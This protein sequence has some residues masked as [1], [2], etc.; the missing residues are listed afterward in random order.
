MPQT[1]SGRGG[2]SEEWTYWVAS[3]GCSP[4]CR[5]GSRSARAHG[6]RGGGGGLRRLRRRWPSASGDPASARRRCSPPQH[7]HPSPPSYGAAATSASH[8]QTPPRR[9]D[10]RRTKGNESAY[11]GGV[12]FLA[13]ARL[14][15]GVF[16]RRPRPN[17]PRRPHHRRRGSLAGCRGQRGVCGC[18]KWGSGRVVGPTGDGEEMRKRKERLWLKRG[19]QMHP[20][21]RSGG[22]PLLPHGSYVRSRAL[23]FF[24]YHRSSLGQ[25]RTMP[26]CW[27]SAHSL[28]SDWGSKS[29]ASNKAWAERSYSTPLVNQQGPFVGYLLFFS[30]M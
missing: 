18:E 12:A 26:V 13:V 20:D 29:Q 21:G 14:P 28:G 5:R 23:P 2:M 15:I 11:A 10:R 6:P 1:D 17:W 22:R 3:C 8:Q 16:G 30:I 27:Q 4:G 9:L 7:L 19:R 25:L 24:F